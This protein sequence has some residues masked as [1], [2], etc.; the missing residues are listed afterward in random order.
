MVHSPPDLLGRER[1]LTPEATGGTAV[2]K[3]LSVH[4]PKVVGDSVSLLEDLAH[5]IFTFMPD[6]SE[7]ID[8]ELVAQDLRRAFRILESVTMAAELLF[9]GY[10]QTNWIGQ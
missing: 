1:N 9:S 3:V 4:D 5:S 2:F 10:C 6:R 7:K 8:A